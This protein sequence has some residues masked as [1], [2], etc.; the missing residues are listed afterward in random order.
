MKL[1]EAISG[2][3]LTLDEVTCLGMLLARPPLP[4]AQRAKCPRRQAKVIDPES[5]LAECKAATAAAVQLSFS[6]ALCYGLAAC[7]GSAP[8]VTLEARLCI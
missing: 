3:S 2:D 5:D 6:W 8:V 7:L 1:D 4:L